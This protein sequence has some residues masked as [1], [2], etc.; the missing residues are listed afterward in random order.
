V[1]LTAG[2][3]H[4]NHNFT[5]AFVLDDKAMIAPAMYRAALCVSTLALAGALATS[6]AHAA[7]VNA[8]SCAQTEV[9]NRINAAVAGDVILVPSGTCTWGAMTIGKAVHVQGSGVGKTN[10]DLSGTLSIV[11]ASNGSVRVSGISF[12]SSGASPMISVTGAWSAAPPLIHNNAFTANGANIMRYETNGGVIYANTFTGSADTNGI[13]HK[14]PTNEGQSWTT[15][16]SLGNRDTGGVKNLYVEGNTFN[17]LSNVATDFDDGARVVFRYNTMINS[18]VNSH[19]L[20]TSHV[21]VR[22]YE[23]YNNTFRYPSESVNQNWWMWLRGGTGVIFG[24][25]VDNIVGQ[26]WGDKTELHFSVRAADD[27]APTGCCTTYPCKHQVGQNYDGTRYY[28]DPV[29]IWGNSGTL[30]WG[31]SPWPSKCGN[32]YQDFLKNGRDFVFASAPKTGYT[33][34]PYPHPLA[35]GSTAPPSIAAPSNLRITQ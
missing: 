27:G 6:S 3:Y 33:P 25:T 13:Q 14:L 7:T 18:G 8:A 22:H 15:A 17:G 28:T 10:V 20:A 11:K 29:T 2:P 21:G 35:T 32:N 16:D 5:T 30:G 19:G 1:K 4:D 24:N 9:Q 26:E 23:I 34:Y 12:A 31:L